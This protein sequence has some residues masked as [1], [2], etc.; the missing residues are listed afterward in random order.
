MLRTLGDATLGVFALH[1][2]IM[3]LVQDVVW[4]ADGAASSGTIRMFV[5]LAIVWCATYAIVLV[6]RRVPVVRAV[7]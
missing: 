7:L 4:P 5:R 6:L 1:L 3:L 2:T